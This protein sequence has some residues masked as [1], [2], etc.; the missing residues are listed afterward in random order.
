MENDFF[1]KFFARG[2]SYWLTRFVILRLLGFVYAVAF[3]VAAKQ[4]VPLVGRNGLTPA[5]DYLDHIQSMLGSRVEGMF[6]LPTL[7]WFGSSDLGMSIFAWVGLALSLVVLGGYANALLLAILWAMYM[8]IVHVG[9]FWYGY[10]W[11]IQLLET[12]FLSIF[13]GPLLDGRPFP[14]C[15]PPL[16]VLWL[17][18]WL[19]FRIMVGAGLIKLRGDPCWRDLTCMFYHY[20]TQPIPSPISRYLHFAPQWFHKFGTLWNHF[21]EL[22]VPWFSFGPRT[23]RHVAGALLLLFQIFLIISGNLSFLNYLTIIPFLA[24]FDDTLLR[25]VLPKAIVARAERAAQ[26][27]EP[28]RIN[29]RIALA[30]SILVAYLSLGPVMNLISHRQ[31]M[32][33]A[34]NRLDLVNTYGAFGTVG[35]ERDEII[36]EGTEDPVTSGDTTWKEYEFV[37]KPGDPDRRPPFIAPYQPRIDWQIWFAAMAS[38]RE[39]PWTFHFV[40]KLLHNDAGTLSLLANNP[41][42]DKPPHFVRARFYR[43][44]FAPLG[45]KGWWRRELI[46]EWL[47]AFSADDEKLRAIMSAMRW[48]DYDDSR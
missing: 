42:P 8:S 33:T 31:M 43:Y 32:N 7:F 26:E 48:R 29:N 5:H 22:V 20:E 37:A 25:H 16:L 4:I 24:C 30:L 27:S 38:P 3:F 47:P 15:R 41:F 44:R 10:G 9:Q 46:G 17:F 14:K 39:Y 19:G 34:F 18:R 21:T 2:N 45:E 1:E 35:R 6:Q 13:L 36:F 12:G 23:V 28:S 11:E 40:W